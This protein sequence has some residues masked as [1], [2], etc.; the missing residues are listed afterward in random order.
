MRQSWKVFLALLILITSFMFDGCTDDRYS[1]AV[2][3]CTCV[4]RGTGLTLDKNQS[5][6]LPP[7][8]DAVYVHV[9]NAVI[10]SFIDNLLTKASEQVWYPGAGITFLGLLNKQGDIPVIDDPDLSS[11]K[12]GEVVWSPQGG[13]E[14]AEI[15]QRC[16]DLW[17][18]AA[19]PDGLILIIARDLINTDGSSTGL[20]G[21][22]EADK[23]VIERNGGN[24]LCNFPRNLTKEDMKGKFILLNDPQPYVNP[25]PYTKDFWSVVLAHEM[26]HV[27]LL[28]HGDGEDNN[29]NSLVP[30]NPGSRKFDEFCDADEFKMEGTEGKVSLMT[31]HAGHV[32]NITELQKE[33]ARTVAKLMPGAVG[34]P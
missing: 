20:S 7:R 2:P 31:E 22:V 15:A 12:Y 4:L 1:I 33:L 24:D 34:P 27:L 17:G 32:K 26:G 3:V 18:R 6:P 14:G 9:P 21:F 19:I 5:T 13:S 29:G 28:G 10:N 23:K 25:N 8:E 30:P 16:R 11:G